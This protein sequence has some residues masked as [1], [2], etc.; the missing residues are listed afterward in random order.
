[1]KKFKKILTAM[2]IAIALTVT[3]MAALAAEG[4]EAAEA[5]EN[6]DCTAGDVA[7]EN[8]GEADLGTPE[9]EGY[10]TETEGDVAENEGEN[11]ANDTAASG[12]NQTEN[13]GYEEESKNT[14]E[15]IYELCMSHLAEILSLAAFLGSLISAILYKSGLL[16]LIERGL[17]TIS[18]TAHSIKES[19]ELGE[20]TRKTD[21][22]G[23]RKKLENLEDTLS[24]LSENLTDYAERLESKSALENRQKRME[25]LTEA[26]VDMLYEIFMTSALPEYEKAR[27]GERVAKMKEVINTYEGQ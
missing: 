27:I 1:M 4:D 10:I 18:K 3:P 11:Q 24:A 8:E 5:T 13:Q 7:L 14:F 2:A 9:N 22:D 21:Y 20:A 17:A 26:E 6:Q 23:L 19:A 15:A 25:T 16:P 12:E